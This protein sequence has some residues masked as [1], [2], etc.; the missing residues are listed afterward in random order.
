MPHR[1]S[2][3]RNKRYTQSR[4]RSVASSRNKETERSRNYRLSSRGFSGRDA[5]RRKD[6]DNF[7]TYSLG[8]RASRIATKVMEA[9]KNPTSDVFFTASRDTGIKFTPQIVGDLAQQ[10]NLSQEQQTRLLGG[11]GRR[12][13]KGSVNKGSLADSPISS[14]NLSSNIQRG[15]RK[16][17]TGGNI[18]VGLFGT[19]GA[20]KLISTARLDNV[21]AVFRDLGL[22]LVEGLFKDDPRRIE[23]NPQTGRFKGV[24]ENII[25]LSGAE[26]A[27]AG[28]LGGTTKTAFSFLR[29]GK[30]ALKV[31][32]SGVAVNSA[33][34]T[35]GIVAKGGETAL[36]RGFL[37]SGARTFNK[38]PLFK[39]GLAVGTGVG[40]AN[41]ISSFGR[42]GDSAPLV[43][44]PEQLIPDINIG[45]GN[46]GEALGGL[47]EALGGLFSGLG[48][49]GGSLVKLGSGA[50]NLGKGF[51]EG[52]SNLG[53]GFG[54]VFQDVK[55]SSGNLLLIGAVGLGTYLIF[56]D[57]K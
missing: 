53:G 8:V 4:N 23:V 49:F 9:G 56:K 38:F 24:L 42:T 19:A 22:S 3:Q 15:D 50:S 40:V 37:A 2:R 32:A 54:E 16:S 41:V 26:V 39:T 28:L 29:G 36:K 18:G 1:P 47:G 44:F 6:A 10:F 11:V 21:G 35:A 7:S 34:T 31:G 55:D 30:S 46:L 13:D 14:T 45:G 33:K 20:E 25:P 51:V 17:Q 57:K 5:Q 43:K 52:V 27:L 48:D 12:E